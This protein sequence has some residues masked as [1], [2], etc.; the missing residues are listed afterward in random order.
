MTVDDTPA[1]EDVEDL[2]IR[3]AWGHLRE[4][5]DD[6]LL[7][8]AVQLGVRDVLVDKGHDD[9]VLDAGGLDAGALVRL[10]ERVEDAG[11]RLNAIEQLP[12]E[13]FE[14]II[15][16]QDGRR[17]Q[18]EVFENSVRALG[19]AGIPILGFHWAPSGV[20]RTSSTHRIRG[21]ARTTAYDHDELGEVA[22]THGREFSEEELWE[23]YEWF[24]ERIVPVAEEAGVKLALHPNDPPIEGIGGVP[25][26]FRDLESFR[27]GID[28]TYPSDNL[29]LK[30]GFGC[31]SQMEG[32]DPLDAIEHFGEKIFY[33]HFRDVEGSGHQFHE[34]FVDQG[35]CSMYEAI[36]TMREAGATPALTPDHVPAVIGDTEDQ[37]RGY[38]FTLGYLTGIVDAL[39]EEH[40]AEPQ[41]VAE[42]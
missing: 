5:I 8:Y 34:T 27:R 33:V 37:H 40:P 31:W 24:V 17:E 11:L 36:R 26:L 28:E 39:D 15:L 2:P 42:T 38:G 14:E 4:P 9:S 22:H 3:P 19:E 16:G 35:N 20:W 32:V 29:G 23:N 13:S 25:F 41:T 21:G 10:R 7:Q 30:M 6:D 1:I 12:T 18:L